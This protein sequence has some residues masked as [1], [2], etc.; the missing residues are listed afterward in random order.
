[1]TMSNLGLGPGL[2][3]IRVDEATQPAEFLENNRTQDN[4]LS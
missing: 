1:M 4:I 3:N 2:R